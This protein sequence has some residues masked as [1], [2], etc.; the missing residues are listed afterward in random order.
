MKIGE[1]IELNSDFKEA[2]RLME[3]TNENV[4]LTGRAGTGK[5]T[6]LQYFRDNTKKNAVVLA[7]TGVAA[8]N[9]KGQTIHSFFQFAPGV[10]VHNIRKVQGSRR[11]IYKNINTIIID[12]V[13]M[14]RSDLLDCVDAS[15]R[16]N[17]PDKNLPFGGIQMIFVG[18]LYQLPPVVPSDEAEIFETYYDGPYFFNAKVF[19]NLQLF[20][21]SPF[22]LIELKK[23]YRQKDK[24]FIKI[25]DCIR[26]GEATDEHLEIINKKVDQNFSGSADD[27][28]VHLTSTNYAAE[29][30]NA[31]KLSQIK[32]KYH[33]FE[34]TVSGEFTKG[35]L[36]TNET[37][38]LKEGAQIMMLNN[39]S[40]KKWVN[41]DVGKIIK[42]EDEN[43]F[44][45][46]T[47]G[48]KEIVVPYT[49]KRVKYFYNESE[50][51]IDSQIAGSFTQYPIKLAWAVTIH[52]GQGQTFDKVI[53]DFGRGTFAFGQ[54]YVALSRC[55]GL[56]GLVLRTPLEQRHIFTD[57]R[58]T[59]F[60]EKFGVK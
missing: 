12:E 28:Y 20:N 16:I 43:V 7:P 19:D 55:T 6:L 38:V 24:E 4:F 23:I 46:L 31:E 14:V 3:D 21:N 35:Y 15:L 53:V 44:I 42:I 41:G 54:S 29:R 5:S 27:F 8:V 30:I 9:V 58:I 57:E 33:E 45:E 51:H 11:R 17:G 49:W 26:K 39:D 25:L 47:D 2:L 22:R 59:E 40:N 10:T 50:G 32:N 60:M 18:D 36:P 52:K 34:G 1:N 56:E 48:R 37:L 13:S